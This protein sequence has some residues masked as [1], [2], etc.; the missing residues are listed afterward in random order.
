MSKYLEVFKNGVKACVGGKVLSQEVNE[1]LNQMNESSGID[2]GLLVPEEVVEE[3]KVL[4]RN[5]VSL[6]NYVH[7]EPV[8]TNK[9]KLDVLIGNVQAMNEVAEEGAYQETELDGE[10]IDVAYEVK[11]YGCT[12][13]LR[14]ELLVD[15]GERFMNVLRVYG[16]MKSR[17]TRNAKILECIESNFNTEKISINNKQELEKVVSEKIDTALTLGSIILTNQSGYSWMNE[18]GDQ[19]TNWITVENGVKLFKGLYP[20]VVMDN[21]ELP[22]KESKHPLIFGNLNEGILLADREAMSIDF[23]DQVRGYWE[24]DLVAMKIYDRIDVKQLDDKAIV[25]CEIVE[26]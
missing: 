26:V 6:E 9:G 7:V 11:K 4:K 24:K 12:K 22:S 23:S 3:I 21:R 17:A 10:F 25:K 13:K 2:G 1:I 14:R 18:I 19:S 15:A 20:I 8:E 16:A 5:G